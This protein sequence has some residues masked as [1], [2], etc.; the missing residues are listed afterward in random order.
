MIEARHAVERARD[1]AERA[2]HAKS[3]FLANMSH[4]IRTPLNGMLG[5]VQLLEL[6]GL[7]VRQA[8]YVGKLRYSA[9]VLLGVINDILDF[10]KIEAGQLAIEHLPFD[11]HDVIENT[12]ALLR[13]RAES[14]GLTFRVELADQVP[15]HLVGDALRLTQVL[16]NLGSNAIKFTEQGSITLRVTGEAMSALVARLQVAVEDTGIGMTDAELG[17]L[18]QSFAQ[19]DS[20][21][22]RRFGGSG[23]GLAICKHL[24]EMMGDR[25][26]PAA[27]RGRAA[28]S[29]STS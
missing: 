20:S 9:D 29:V 16:N 22:S 10:S 28:C 18:F 7:D 8:G 25:S 24:V 26:R 13:T 6:S 27:F 11:L 21:I 2:N 12:A 1:E 4:E 15:H 17:R 5:M 23:L 3:D 14:K 19:A